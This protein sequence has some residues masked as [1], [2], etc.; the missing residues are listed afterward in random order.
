VPAGATEYSG[1]LSVEGSQTGWTG[2]Y[3]SNSTVT[4]AEPAGGSYDGLWALQVGIKSGSGQGGVSNANPVWV[5]ST[6]QG[7]AYQASS[8]VRGSA[9][10]T[11]SLTLTEKTPGGKAVGYHTTSLTLNDT[12]WHQITGSYTAL[13]SGNLLRYSLHGYLASPSQSFQADCLSLQ[14]P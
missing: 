14:G 8:F 9:G 4:R 12:S 1:N 6:S 5:T 2:A 7:R 11:V 10:E 3:N 13:G